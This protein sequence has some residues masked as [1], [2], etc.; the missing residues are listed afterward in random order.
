[1]ASSSTAIGAPNA[2][3]VP[4]AKEQAAAALTKRKLGRLRRTAKVEE[5]KATLGAGGTEGVGSQKGEEVVDGELEEQPD[6]K[7]AR[8]S[9][10]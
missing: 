3:G 2:P 5:V 4:T 6:T 7:R 9:E 1:M 10:D 8:S